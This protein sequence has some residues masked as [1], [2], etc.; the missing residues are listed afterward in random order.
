MTHVWNETNTKLSGL[1]KKTFKIKVTKNNLFHA[2]GAIKNY[3]SYN[4]VNVTPIKCYENALLN[5]NIILT[6]NKNESG[7]Y[8]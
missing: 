4:N 8:R 1:N 5:K 6:E 7:I 3:S 2:H